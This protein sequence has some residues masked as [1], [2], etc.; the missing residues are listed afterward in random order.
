M[1]QPP[2]KPQSKV[3]KAP[4]YAVFAIL[5][6]AVLVGAYSLPESS[7]N[8]PRRPI[9]NVVVWSAGGGTD[10]ANRMVAVELGEALGIDVNVANKPG[11]IAGSLGMN[12]V[13]QRASDGYTLVGISESCVTAAVMGGW[14]Q[15]MD[16]W[17]PFV[18][19]GSTDLISVGADSEINSLEELVAYAKENP[20]TIKAAA[21]GSGSLHHL[22]LLAFLK[23]T[24]IDM[25][26]VPYPG[27]APAQTA[28][29]TKE[30]DLV[31]TSLAEQQQLI[32]GGQLRPLAMLGDDDFSDPDIGDVPSALKAYPSLK[33]YLPIT[34]VIG[35]AIRDD[36][37][38]AVK[39][40]LDRAFKDALQSERLQ[41]WAKD[42]YFVLSGAS[43]EEAKEG[44]AK[45]ESLFAWT[46][47]ELG[48][49]RRHPDTLGINPP[50]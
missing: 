22:N 44:F 36:A 26:F 12:Y 14:D 10:V 32:K 7:N 17:H 25:R 39:D 50:N 45:L 18:I 23:G 4:V 40:A 48:V 24:G 27:S 16:V 5:V 49:T 34:Q 20:G 8:Y 30:V 11:G 38:P 2:V 31:I 1:D 46:L 28:A 47:H 42:N 13:K 15:K 3:R 35:F 9:T 21:G 37:D 41:R 6:V 19:G 33:Q 29:V 43:G